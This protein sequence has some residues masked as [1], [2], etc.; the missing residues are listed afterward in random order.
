MAQ[1]VVVLSDGTTGPAAAHD[2][3]ER[4]ERVVATRAPTASVRKMHPGRTPS[5]LDAFWQVNIAD[6]DADQAVEDLLSIPGVDGAYV[7]P[8]DE[9]P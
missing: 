1:I 2:V 4:I 8:P 6:E 9:P 5:E 3:I 7:K